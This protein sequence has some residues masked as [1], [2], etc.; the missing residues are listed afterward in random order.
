MNQKF[1]KMVFILIIIWGFRPAFSGEAQFQSYFGGRTLALNGL[2]IAGLDG[3]TSHLNNPA[4]PAYLSGYGFDAALI[5]KTGEY[6]YMQYDENIYKSF[7]EDDLLL[8]AGAYWN[9]MPDLTIALSY[10][11]TLVY[12]VDWPYAMLL[13]GANKQILLT[14]DYYNHISANA[15]NFDLAYRLN[16]VAIGVALSAYHVTSQLAFPRTTPPVNSSGV[17]LVEA[18]QYKYEQDAWTFGVNLGLSWDL[19]DAWR[20]GFVLRSGYKASLKGNVENTMLYDLAMADTNF[21]GA[22]PSKST[23]MRSDLEIPMAAGFGLL[24][25]VN[26]QISLN[27]DALYHFWAATQNQIDIQYEDPAWQSALSEKDSLTHVVPGQMIMPDQNALEIGA[28]IE[29]RSSESL[30]L[31]AGYRFSQSPNSN[32]TYSMHSPVVSQHWISAGLGYTEDNYTISVAL[33]YA[34]GISEAVNEQNNP[35]WYGSYTGN[36]F[37]PSVSL[38][39][40]F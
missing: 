34:I 32:A 6:T 37:I 8:G 2:Y 23:Q 9:I 19:S 24:Y 10:L 14:F 36:T 4:A 1:V 15:L 7:R 18:Y 33:A 25:R 39:Y 35:D 16:T 27:F 22:P 5:I 38:E 20:L 30:A 28:G 13:G 29:Y 11:P 31:R 40:G 3:S 26:D 17:K 21:T 12:K